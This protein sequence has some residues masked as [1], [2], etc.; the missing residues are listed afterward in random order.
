MPESIPALQ[1][2]VVDDEP[3]ARERLC[4]LLEGRAEVER[5]ETAASG[6]AA[7]KAIQSLEPDL[8]F[9][10]VQMPGLDGLDV[11]RE[12]GPDAMPVTVFV[13]AYDQYALNAF[14]LAAIDYLL[15][16]F[17]DERFEQAFERAKETIQLRTL[18]QMKNRLA[19]L[20]QADDEEPSSAEAASSDADTKYLERVAVESRGQVR[21]VPVEEIKYIKSDGP[22]LELY[23]AEEKHLI[24]E[25]MKTLEDRLDPE[26]FCRIHRSAIVR[27]DQIEAFLRQAGGRYAV[28]LKDGTRLSVSRS[29]REAL[30]EQLGLTL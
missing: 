23:T 19:A 27:L 16:P 18:G 26:A 6:T 25:R 20:L 12:I 17:D 21:I 13:T 15:K 5:I 4:D 28:R 2:L 29:R 24:R 11:V 22:Y 30:E 1:V 14:E 7:V 8:V 9:L 10:D 3:L